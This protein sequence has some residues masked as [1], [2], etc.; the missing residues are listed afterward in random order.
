MSSSP[1]ISVLAIGNELLDG[2]VTDTNST[3]IGFE[4][5]KIGLSLY[6]TATCGDTVEEIV[7][8]LTSL[9]EQSDLVIISGGLGPTTD[10]LTRE[11]VASL[12]NVK[13]VQDDLSLKHIEKYFLKRNRPL[14]EANKRQAFLPQGA[15][16]IENPV[17]SAPGFSFR[18]SQAGADKIIFALPGVPGELREMCFKTVF[19]SI[20]SLFPGVIPR[21]EVGFRVFGLPESE[22]GQRLED[23]KLPPEIEIC[24][25]VI[26]PEIEVLLRHSD[27]SILKLAISLATEAI[28][29]EYVLSDSPAHG[30]DSVVMDLC[31]KNKVTL[32][33]AESCTGGMFGEI[34][35]AIPGSSKFYLGG[36]VSYSNELKDKFLGVSPR[37]IETHGAVS[38]EVAEAMAI[39]LKEKTKADYAISIT[40]VAGPDGGTE[41][42]PVGTVFIGCASRSGI[43]TKKIFLPASRERIRRYACYIGLDLAR[44]MILQLSVL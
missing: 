30:L 5:R 7:S 13:L 15:R 29:S 17:G 18:I 19:P 42:N 16:Y 8:S 20:N 6:R 23:K 31:I 35:T 32:A 39:G 34:I 43:I 2:R 37:L 3:W 44:R 26:F 28:G 27:P 36:V 12:G 25:R 24:Y 9:F 41:A 4:L 40:G 1:R 11:S 22:I 10:D 38:K 33:T 21:A 14:N